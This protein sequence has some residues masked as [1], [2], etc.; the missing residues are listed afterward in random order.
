MRAPTSSEDSSG[1][2]RRILCRMRA[3]PAAMR[4]NAERKRSAT[5]RGSCDLWSI[6]CNTSTVRPYD[7]ARYLAAL[8]V[9][10]LSAQKAPVS[11]RPPS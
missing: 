5:A 11:I 9:S 3:A 10:A 1:C 6:A 8:T 7:E 2:S 4:S